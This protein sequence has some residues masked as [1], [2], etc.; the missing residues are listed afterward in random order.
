MLKSF[1]SP[2]KDYVLKKKLMEEG[3]NFLNFLVW[4]RISRI[5]KF[6]KRKN[7]SL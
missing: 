2:Y 7:P 4:D 3:I 6:R 1:F 5:S